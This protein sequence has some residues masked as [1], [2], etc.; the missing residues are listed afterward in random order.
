MCGVAYRSVALWQRVTWRAMRMHQ[1]D[2]YV[3]GPYVIVADVVVL[4]VA[5]MACVVARMVVA[6]DAANV[7]RGVV[8][9][10]VARVSA[11][12]RGGV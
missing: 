12:L 9:R 11:Y 4:V 7:R 8:W 3:S 6:V 2:V 1:T 5:Y 10:G